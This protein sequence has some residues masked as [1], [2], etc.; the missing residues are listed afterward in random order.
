[1]SEIYGL[2]KETVGI[3]RISEMKFLLVHD[4]RIVLVFITSLTAVKKKKTILSGRRIQND[5]PLAK[6]T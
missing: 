5:K 1:M 6:Y 3:S 4:Q 2:I